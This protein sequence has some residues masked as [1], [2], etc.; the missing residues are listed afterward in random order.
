MS[1]N[2]RFLIIIALAAALLLF[3]TSLSRVINNNHEPS[4][5]L[6]SGPHSHKRQPAAAAATTKYLT[7]RQDEVE[8]FYLKEKIKMAEKGS[9]KRADAEKELEDVISHRKH[10]DDSMRAIVKVLVVNGQINAT[11]SSRLFTINTKAFT[12]DWKCFKSIVANFQ[13]HC[14]TLRLY[15]G[16]YNQLY[17]N[18]CDA[19]VTPH[20]WA[21]ASLQ[22]CPPHTVNPKWMAEDKMGF[23]ERKGSGY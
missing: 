6:D 17:A 21:V 12:W 3:V 20:Q 18:L 23:Y 13:E 4:E 10:I 2:L 7:L 11:M 14:G 16:K 15:G 5:I 22:T 8:I 9:D 19:G 1:A